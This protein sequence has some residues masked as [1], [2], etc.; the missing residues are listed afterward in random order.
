MSSY[1]A[2]VAGL[3]PETE[4]DHPAH[5]FAEFVENVRWATSLSDINIAAGIAA[6]Q[7]DPPRL[8]GRGHLHLVPVLALM[9]LFALAGFASVLGNFVFGDA[10]VHELAARLGDARGLLGQ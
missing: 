2:A 5:V 4:P 6:Q 8:R 9:T 7:L 3:Y 1:S 10:P